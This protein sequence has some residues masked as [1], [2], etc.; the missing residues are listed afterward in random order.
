MPRSRWINSSAPDVR[1]TNPETHL[2]TAVLSQAVH[3]VFSTHVDKVDKEQAVDFLTE[4]TWH[5]RMICELAGRNPD[6][7]RSKIRKK[8]LE[9]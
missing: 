5:L 3:D 9:T 7:V 1:K 6:Y 8:L 4:D 2:F